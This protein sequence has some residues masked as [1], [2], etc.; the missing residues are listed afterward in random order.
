MPQPASSNTIVIS[1]SYI[2]IP[3]VRVHFPG[4]QLHNYDELSGL[5]VRVQES[6]QKLMFCTEYVVYMATLTNIA[7]LRCS[8]CG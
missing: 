3:L 4:T 2:Y 5:F 8:K 1:P 7:K 6:N